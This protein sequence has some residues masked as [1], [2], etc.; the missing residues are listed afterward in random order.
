MR[1]NTR[2]SNAKAAL[3]HQA[4]GT[5]VLAELAA[6]K[7]IIVPELQGSW[8]VMFG[9][10]APNASRGAWSRRSMTGYGKRHPVH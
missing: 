8:R 6:L 7:A 10:P 3:A 5:E 4:A 2:K 1:R 9:E